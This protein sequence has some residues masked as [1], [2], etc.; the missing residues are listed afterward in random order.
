MKLTKKELINELKDNFNN[1]SFIS[2]NKREVIQINNDD[3]AH[4]TSNPKSNSLAKDFKGMEFEP[5]KEGNTLVMITIS[6]LIPKINPHSLDQ[7]KLK[8][9]QAYWQTYSVDHRPLRKSEDTF[10]RQDDAEPKLFLH[11]ELSMNDR[12]I[13]VKNG[14]YI[15]LALN[16]LGY[17]YI[18]IQVPI[19]QANDFNEFK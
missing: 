2:P 16:N 14:K 19:H 18:N 11:P 9:A 3:W 4:W 7:N 13:D 12:M 17:K 10:E 6:K 1:P 5:P 15:I 8:K